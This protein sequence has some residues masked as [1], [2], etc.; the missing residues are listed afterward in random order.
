MTQYA[1]FPRHLLS[2]LPA[3]L[4]VLFNA[5]VRGAGYAV[6]GEVTEGMVVVDAIAGASVET[7][8]ARGMRG[9]P[10]EPVIIEKVS[11]VSNDG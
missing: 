1:P 4:A 10:V 5:G 2:P 7:G 8:Y 11:V 9:V 6:F 3:A